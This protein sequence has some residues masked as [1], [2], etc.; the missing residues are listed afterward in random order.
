MATGDNNDDLDL[1]TDEERA[2]LEEGDT[3]DDGEGDDGDDGNDDDDDDDDKG[4]GA[5]DGEGDAGGDATGGKDAGAGADD[6][7]GRDDGQD[8]DSDD[9]AVTPPPAANRVDA[10]ATQ[11]RLGAIDTEQNDLMEK[12][13]DGEITTKEFTAALNKLNDEKNQLTN[14]LSQQESADKAVHERWYKDVNQFL[15]KNPEL[16]AN[17][18]RLQSFD[19]VVRRVTGDPANASLSNKKQ[20]ELAKTTWREEMGYSE[21]AK[22]E[23]KPAPKT[24]DGK[25]D[26]KKPASAKPALPP[27]L[28]NVPA[29]DIEIGD[30]GKFSHLEAL[31]NTGKTI[32]FEAALARL[33]EADQQDYLSRS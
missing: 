26:G 31:L 2:G 24:A 13:D 5:D 28:H 32:E 3:I 23:P 4:G 22:T 20:L 33:S 8:D 15:D 12:L 21:P 9:G 6:Q 7:G 27:T 11:T 25:P 18:T 1:L 29:A 19:A 16:K 10:Q 14:A 30:D 17:D